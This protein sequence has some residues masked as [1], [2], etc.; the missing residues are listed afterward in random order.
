MQR[1][2]ELDSGPVSYIGH[3]PDATP[4]KFDDRTADGESHAHAAGFGS[5]ESI[6]QPI[7]AIRGEPHTGIPH[8][9]SHIPCVIRFRSD[10]ELAW[11]IRDRL[12]G[13][14]TVDHQIE[15]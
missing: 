8:G 9:D 3:S 10:Y 13:F 5:V 1:Q 7:G 4:V 12:H 2:N 14:N 6:E 15:D 11:S